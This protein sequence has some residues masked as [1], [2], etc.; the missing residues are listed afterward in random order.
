MCEMSVLCHSAAGMAIQTLIVDDHEDIRL[1]VRL[2]LGKESDIE[3]AGE[4]RDGNEA[5]DAYRELRPN[6]IVLDQMMPGMN[7]L[8][9]VKTLRARGDEPR[10]V[11]FSAYIDTQVQEAASDLGV[12]QCVSKNDMAS[13]VGAVRALAAL[14]GVA[15]ST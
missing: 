15:A 9:V 8:E 7:G 10:V 4:A 2:T 14:G 13:L 6:V 1:L 11:L 3:V 12:D 5:I